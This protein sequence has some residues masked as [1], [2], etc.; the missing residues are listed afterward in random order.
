MQ[1]RVP[2]VSELPK[3]CVVTI[4]VNVSAWSSFTLTVRVYNVILTQHFNAPTLSIYIT[5]KFMAQSFFVEIRLLLVTLE[6]VAQ[7]IMFAQKCLYIVKDCSISHSR[8][9][10]GQ[11]RVLQ[12]P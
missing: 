2:R 7:P 1:K 3:I 5:T 11:I 6:S 4:R 8:L 12:F 10:F 9:R